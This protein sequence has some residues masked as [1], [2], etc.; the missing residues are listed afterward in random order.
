[1]GGFLLYPSMPQ[2]A[3]EFV[4]EAFSGIFV[5][6]SSFQTFRN[7]VA[8][9]VGATCI[10][11]ILGLSIFAPT[12]IVT[13]NGLLVGLVIH[14][15]LGRGTLTLH[16]LF[17]GIAPHAIFE[18]PAFLLSASLGTRIGFALLSHGNL[19]EKFTILYVRLREGIIT[20]IILILPLL[21]IAAWIEAY[22]T[23]ALILG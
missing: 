13:I 17:F 23:S 4:N 1:M 11:L 9:N 15:G 10:T 19:V 16:Q 6:N 2:K 5:P 22:I 20:Y 21:I 8:R 14:S 3:D 12:L 18:L 7:I